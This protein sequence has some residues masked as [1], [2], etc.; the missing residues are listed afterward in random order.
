MNETQYTAA[1]PL[2]KIEQDT[3]EF[4]DHINTVRPDGKRAWIFAKKPQGKFYRW[5]TLVSIVLLVLLFAGPFVRIHGQPLL[6]LNI[7]ERKFILFGFVFWPQD[8]YLVV[9]GL[10]TL[11]L[12]IVLFTSVFGRIWC[13]WAC[14]Q[15]IFMEM[16]FRKI[17]Y[18]LEGDFQEQKKLAAAPWTL[19]KILRKAAKFGIFYAISFAIANTFLAYI[20]G[21][22]ALLKIISE[23]IAQHLTGF[24]AI[25]IFTLIFFLVFAR[26]R[27]QVCHFACPYGRFQSV[28]VDNDTICVTYDFQ[29]G[30]KR[31]TLGQRKKAGVPITAGENSAATAAQFGDCI[32]CGSCVGVCPAG[33]DIRNGIQLEC[34]QCTACLD[35][36]NKMMD[37][38]KRPRGLIR[39]TST[40]RSNTA[41]RGRSNCAQ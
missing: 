2:L 26:F 29:R 12:T 3:E 30:E 19:K 17:E 36:C 40:T 27:E 23:P 20:I 6:L 16:V 33:I 11:I 37:A 24:I 38:I 4:R 31:A 32:D 13:G 1:D 9:L 28:L 21:S 41:R 35:A 15:T 5:R 10:L 14:P 8:F 39:Y 25:H 22:D 34:I 18:W 7:L